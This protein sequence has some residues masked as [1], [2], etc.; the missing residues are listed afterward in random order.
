MDFIND[1]TVWRV[2]ILVNIFIFADLFFGV[3]VAIKRDELKLSVQKLPRYLKTGVLPYLLALA[4]LA[5]LNVYV[6]EWS[7]VFKE[8]DVYA[9]ALFVLGKYTLD[10][11][12]K[13]QCLFS[14]VAT[15]TKEFD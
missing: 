4:G 10:I 14:D 5:A 3:A 7:L 11:K 15:D 6:P 12:D 2:L 9:S 13:L 1:L 8:V